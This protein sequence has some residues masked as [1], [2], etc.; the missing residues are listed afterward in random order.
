LKDPLNSRAIAA[1]S[2]PQILD[3]LPDGAYIT[4]CDRRIVF[5]NKSAERILGWPAT[6]VVGRNCSDNILL[7]IDQDGHALC[8]NE[9]CPLHRC[10]VTGAPSEEPILV[11]AKHRSGNRIPVEVSVAP[12]RDDTGEVIGGIELFRDLSELESDLTRAREIQNS[13]LELNLPDDPRWTFN[14]KY[15]PSNIV[16]GDFFR[17]EQ[18]GKRHYAVMLADVMGH[19][20]APALYTM[21]LRQLWEELQKTKRGHTI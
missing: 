4:D 9:Y 8:G 15:T 3:T 2:G 16:G 1:I 21:L 19:G 7:H 14:T 18:I 5:W 12:I 20:V 10:I 6:E 17:I 13:L 11:Y